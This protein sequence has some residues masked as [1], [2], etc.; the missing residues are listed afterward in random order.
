MN[1]LRLIKIYELKGKVHPIEKYIIDLIN[2]LDIVYKDNYEVYQ[3]YDAY[4]MEYYFETNILYIY[5][6]FEN[7]FYTEFKCYPDEMYAIIKY[8]LEKHLKLEINYIQ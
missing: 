3:K 2:D 5:G 1:K 8:L 6:Y 4:Y 7:I